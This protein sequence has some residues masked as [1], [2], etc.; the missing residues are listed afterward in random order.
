[1]KEVFQFFGRVPPTPQEKKNLSEE[2]LAAIRE[3]TLKEFFEF[4]AGVHWEKRVLA[5]DYDGTLSPFH[6]DPLRAYPYPGVVER[7]DE[8]MGTGTRT[9]IATGRKVVEIPQILFLKKPIEICGVHGWERQLPDG[10]FSQAPMPPE[11]RRA[12][13]WVESWVALVEKIGARYERKHASIVVH[14]RALMDAGDQTGIE[15]VVA[16]VDLWWKKANRTYLSRDPINGG[17]EIRAK[18]WNKGMVVTGLMQDADAGAF[19]GDDTTDEDA[20]RA[21]KLSETLRKKVLAILVQPEWKRSSDAIAHLRPPNEL[22]S[23]L[24]RWIDVCRGVKPAFVS[25]PPM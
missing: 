23:F 11:K 16:H 25:L 19:L 14:Y 1:M 9:V 10:S 21:I 18:G 7:L 12:L 24:D 20:F 8:I 22:L 2:E 4:L 13:D 3:A 6:V 17:I 5:L 15:A